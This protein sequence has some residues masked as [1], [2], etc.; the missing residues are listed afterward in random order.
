M[1]KKVTNHS[2]VILGL[3][4]SFG[5]F[6]AWREEKAPFAFSQNTI[7]KS[8]HMSNKLIGYPSKKNYTF[9]L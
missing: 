9:K 5:L 1:K 2:L 8:D 3:V 6:Q 7:K 4:V